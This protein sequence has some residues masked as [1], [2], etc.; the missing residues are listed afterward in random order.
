VSVNAAAARPN[1][2]HRLSAGSNQA[3]DIAMQA[4]RAFANEN[5]P[6]VQRP[7]L[8]LVPVE[9]G[10]SAAE[11]QAAEIGR[12]DAFRHGLPAVTPLADER[13]E[14]IRLFASMMRRDDRR[15][16]AQ[17]E[18]LLAEGLSRTALRQ[19]IDVALG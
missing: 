4:A 17:A 19:V 18:V 15:V 9:L 6:S 14:R 7:H 3:E 16:H 8:R 1:S 5:M 13:L 12:D 2:Q 10:L 11:R